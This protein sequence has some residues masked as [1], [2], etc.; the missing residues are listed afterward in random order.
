MASPR[1][2]CLS[3]R[4]LYL[5]LLVDAADLWLRQH[6]GKVKV[7]PWVLPLAAAIVHYRLQV[8]EPPLPLE[9]VQAQAQ[10]LPGVALSLPPVLL[11][12][13]QVRRVALGLALRASVSAPSRSLVEGHLLQRAQ[14]LALAWELM[15][16][17]MEMAEA[18]AHQL[19]G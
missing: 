16:A 3:H 5:L 8:D 18:S 9:Q 2:D 12:L 14:E 17:V 19:L 13:C 10:A 6:R 15:Q 11:V 4:Y 1:L 7:R